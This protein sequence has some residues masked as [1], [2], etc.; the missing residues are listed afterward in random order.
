MKK[1]LIL[2]VCLLSLQVS[3][4]TSVV[5]NFFD[6]YAENEDFTTVYITGRMFSL[7]A[8]IAPDDED[9]EDM[10]DAASGL[11]GL[12]V[13]QS[14]K[15]D[16]KKMYNSLYNRLDKD[17]YE[18]LMVIKEGKNREL[19]FMIKEDKK[20]VKELL[21]LSGEESEFVLI[22]LYGNIDLEKIAKV[23]KNME[24]DGLEQLQKLDDDGN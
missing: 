7:M 9:A 24:I 5:T 17:G 12:K 19:K 8:D 15:V 1:L 4:Q 11:E 23:T 13:L 18:D 22:Y 3:A 16:G 10:L 2:F 14:D 21:M 20:I 6:K